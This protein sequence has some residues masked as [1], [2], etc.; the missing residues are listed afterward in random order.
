MSNRLKLATSPYLK[1]HAEN[2]VDWYPWGEEAWDRAKA[3]NKPVFLSVGYSSCHWCHVMAHES[4][5]DE[6]TA[7]AL[8]HHFINIKLD[9]EERPD[10]DEIYMTAVQLATGH[11]GWPMSL[12]LTPDKKPFFAGTYFPKESRDGFPSFKTIIL[13]LADAW[14]SQNSEILERA[15][16]FTSGLTQVLERSVAPV[17]DQID[18]ALLD[19]AIQQ[20]HSTFDYEEGGFG[21]NPKFPPHTLLNFLINY[22]QNRNRLPG[23]KDSIEA[24]T[25]DA[26]HMAVLTLRKMAMGGIHDIVGGG[27][28]RYATDGE[29]LLPHFEKMLYDNAQLL[30]IYSHAS[31]LIEDEQMKDKCI[32]VSEHLI[33]WVKREMTDKSGAF[34]SALDADSIDQITNHT[35]EGVF[36]TWSHEELKLVLSNEQLE[37]YRVFPGGNFAD[38]ATQELTGKNILHSKNLSPRPIEFDQLLTIRNRRPMPGLDNKCLCSWNGLMIGALAKA[39]S[40]E[41]AENAAKIWTSFP[42]NEIPHQIV[43]GVPEGRAFLDDYAFLIDGIID[44]AEESKN[45]AWINIARDLADEMLN[46]FADPV[47]GG[48]TFT[49]SHHEQLFGH[50][51][52]A[53][54]NSAPSPNGIAVKVLRRLGQNESSLLHLT[55]LYGWAQRLPQANATILNECM[56]QLLLASSNEITVQTNAPANLQVK[57]EPE[58]PKIAKDGFAYATLEIKIPDGMHINSTSPATTWLT[59]TQVQVSQVYGEAGFPETNNDLY[60]GNL[61]IMLRLKPKSDTGKFTVNLTFQLCS[62]NACFLPQNLE[63]NGNIVF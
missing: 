20:F 2:P 16:E 5:E 53:M 44:L 33:E 4:F 32:E 58:N 45:D 11:G 14:D 36:Y 62:E 34:Y 46:Q 13:N 1:Q 54:D 22:A 12:F 7:E 38:E 61:T 18:T 25:N 21:G 3:E 27:F 41:L 19:Q 9:R 51:K 57:L 31:G 40:F 52:P 48:F 59:P 39:H 17:T 28:H 56:E 42:I 29:W 43:N 37:E 26:G 50:T 55:N 10:I 23:D 60:S 30:A 6:E 15:E 24:L 35:E 8:N 49:A 63:F 47:Y